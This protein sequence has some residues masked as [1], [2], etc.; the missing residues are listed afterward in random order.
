M[1]RTA[2]FGVTGYGGGELLRLLLPHPDVEVVQA[3]SR[4][5]GRRLDVVHPGVRGLTD[6]VL[7]PS[8]PTALDPGLDAIFLG[9]PHGESSGLLKALAARCPRARIFDLAQDFR[10]G[11]EHE[12]W[13]YG[14]PELFG[15]EIAKAQ[16]VACP[17]CFATALILGTAPAVKAGLPLSRIIV[18]AKTGSS[19]SGATPR[20][21]THHPAR[22]ETIKA[23]KIFEHQHETEIKATW[24]RLADGKPLPPLS[25]VPQS[26][27]NV[28]GIYACCYLVGAGERLPDVAA[29]YKRFYAQ[30]RFVDVLDEPP[31]VFDVRGTNRVALYVQATEGLTLV[32]SAIDNLCRGAAGQ[33]V[34][35]LN[36]VFG[37]PEDRGLRLPAMNP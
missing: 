11:W 27:A 7:T 31:N 9:L 10:T 36:L 25:F 17:G 6:L 37:L 29:L 5:A 21:L 34:Q 14:Q 4:E 2:I 23:Y 32:I 8:D 3:T 12:G 19:G 30:A 1:I 20:P 33:A 24:Q 28:R 15:A 13:V 22:V 18:D 35:C 26:V 16:R